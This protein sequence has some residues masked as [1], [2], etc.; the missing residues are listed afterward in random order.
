M[1]SKYNEENKQHQLDMLGKGWL[2]DDTKISG[3]YIVFAKGNNDFSN[4]ISIGLLEKNKDNKNI[5]TM[6]LARMYL[7][8][9]DE[10]IMW[11]LKKL[12]YL[13]IKYMPEDKAVL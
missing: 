12:N 2:L 5:F 1:G 3:Q 6:T 10:K 7:E 9:D 4:F 13:Y 8:E 11:S